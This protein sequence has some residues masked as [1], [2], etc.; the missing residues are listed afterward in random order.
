MIFAFLWDITQRRVVILY[1]R[2]GQRIGPSC[3][4]QEV[5]EN[6]ASLPLHVTQ[7]VGNYLGFQATLGFS[8]WIVLNQIT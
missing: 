5:Q 7:K 3:K 6:G 2:F 1:R 4:S 8:R